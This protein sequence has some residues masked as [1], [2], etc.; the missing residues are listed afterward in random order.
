[1]DYLR[2][3]DM[4][5]KHGAYT[6]PEEI[7]LNTLDENMDEV[8]NEYDGSGENDY[9]DSILESF[10]KHMIVDDESDK[11]EDDK[12]DEF[13]KSSE[14][15]ELE[16]NKNDESEEFETIVHVEKDVIGNSLSDDDDDNNDLSGHI[17]QALE[18]SE[19]DS[20]DE[21]ME[22]IEGAVE[23]SSKKATKKVTKK[24]KKNAKKTK[25]NATKEQHAPVLINLTNSNETSKENTDVKDVIGE[26][27]EQNKELNI[28]Q[29]ELEQE[30]HETDDSE[31][32]EPENDENDEND[33][34]EKEE[35]ENDDKDDKDNDYDDDDNDDKDDKDTN[36]NMEGGFDDINEIVNRFNNIKI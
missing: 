2:V 15:D 33:D 1:M 31:K 22:D 26:D 35:S 12:N 11:L 25:K 30:D 28:S 34:S 29:K 14:S 17:K 21:S 19:M 13:N 4:L 3:Y 20:I 16:D 8:M 24:T 9:F 18:R 5:K 7:V 23:K 36:D 27:S 6:E 10:S 32:E